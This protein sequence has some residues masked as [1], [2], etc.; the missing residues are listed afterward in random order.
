[1]SGLVDDEKNMY[2]ADKNLEPTVAVVASEASDSPYE[3]T[4]V[5]GLKPRHVQVM[6]ISGAI[7]TGLFVR[8]RDVVGSLADCSGR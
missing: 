2:A 5:R 6:A 4:T 7:G 8:S 3:Q 1:M